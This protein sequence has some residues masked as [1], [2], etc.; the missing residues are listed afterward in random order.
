M[1]V[2]FACFVFRFSFSNNVFKGQFQEYHYNV[3]IIPSYVR[4]DLPLA[5]V[6]SIRHHHAKSYYY[7][8]H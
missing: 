8:L 4:S 1:F 5:N 6:I 2:F 7:S 3:Q